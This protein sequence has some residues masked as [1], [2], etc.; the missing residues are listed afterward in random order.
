MESSDQE[1]NMDTDDSM[2]SEES[3]RHYFVQG[4]HYSKSQVERKL[5]YWD[6]EYSNAKDDYVTLKHVIQNTHEEVGSPAA[7]HLAMRA[8]QF[9]KNLRETWQGYKDFMEAFDVNLSHEEKA[10]YLE[11]VANLEAWI[12][13]M[14]TDNA[15]RKEI[16]H[17]QDS[18]LHNMTASDKG[19]LF[20][21]TGNGLHEEQDICMPVGYFD[22][23]IS[24][25]SRLSLIHI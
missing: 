8:K 23:K 25:R 14:N 12:Q 18:N 9:L 19:S 6:R 3:N 11:A 5:Q 20:M 13:I 24:N 22:P 7:I 1:D 21:D 4:R 15:A 16:Q 17:L 2:D 10:E